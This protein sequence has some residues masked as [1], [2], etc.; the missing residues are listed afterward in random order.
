MSS[1][2]NASQGTMQHTEKKHSV[3]VVSKTYYLVIGFEVNGGKETFSCNK[4][5]ITRGRDV[6]ED[7]VCVHDIAN[8][9]YGHAFFYVADNGGKVMTFFSFGPTGFFS[10][11]I[12]G[13]PTPAD[14]AESRPST[15]AYKIT[16]LSQMFRFVID[17]D[18][19]NRIVEEAD[20][21]TRENHSYAVWK[22]STCA[23]EARSV[24]DK[25][26]IK[27]PSGSSK[28]NAPFIGKIGGSSAF[29]YYGFVNPYMWY[30]QL[31]Q[32]YGKAIGFI[33]PTARVFYHRIRSDEYFD[34]K[35][36]NLLK[37]E[38]QWKLTQG[39]DDPLYRF[40]KASSGVKIH[41]KF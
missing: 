28:V 39:S 17:K 23:S 5:K 38:Y 34:P 2:N 3:D 27:T 1:K 9:D 36:E 4:I 13:Q 30:Q 7:T 25:A 19:A 11:K 14:Y 10:N 31:Q 26:G 15:T 41:G 6:L 32:K 37:D 12:S 8:G 29:D 22:N 18:K 40:P 20:K 35:R 24:L 16:E 21:F 33:S